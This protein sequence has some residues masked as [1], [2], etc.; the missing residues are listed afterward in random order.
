MI[1]R[2]SSSVKPSQLPISESDRPHPVHRPLAG[3]MQHDRTQGEIIAGEGCAAL[4]RSMRR[5]ERR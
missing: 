2:R 5:R 1:V 3:S 4:R